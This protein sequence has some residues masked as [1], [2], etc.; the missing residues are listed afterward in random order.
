MP[1]HL[2]AQL[3]IRFERFIKSSLQLIW[4]YLIFVGNGKDAAALIPLW[5]RLKKSG[6]R[7][8]AVAT[9][10]GLAYI[11]AVQANLP[12]ATLVFAHFHIIKLLTNS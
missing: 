1:G 11:S 2:L 8:E 9:D 12:Q 3:I 4:R 6:A 7:I 5:K 10:M